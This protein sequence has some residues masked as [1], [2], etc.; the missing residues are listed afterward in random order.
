MIEDNK[1]PYVSSGHVLTNIIQFI[2]VWQLTVGK[3]VG[4]SIAKGKKSGRF[5][6][7]PLAVCFWRG[8]WRDGVI[9]F[10]IMCF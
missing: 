8:G 6:I 1:W 7:E 3:I 4:I 10:K 5:Y 2:L 9:I